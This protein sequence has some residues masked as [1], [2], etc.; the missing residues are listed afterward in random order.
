[1]TISTISMATLYIIGHFPFSVYYIAHFAF[2]MRLDWLHALVEGFLYLP[3]I[4]KL[5]VYY[6][7]ND[8]FRAEFDR[9]CCIKEEESFEQV[10]SDV[11]PD[12]SVE[13]SNQI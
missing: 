2:N 3:V 5:G 1:M 7:Y 13:I 6:F 4:L 10:S 9:C 11:S 12:F 8:V